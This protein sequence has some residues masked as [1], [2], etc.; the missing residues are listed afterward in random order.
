[1]E[2]ELHVTGETANTLR[3]PGSVAL[4]AGGARPGVPPVAAETKHTRPGRWLTRTR[5]RGV[6]CSQ[7]S[8]DWATLAAMGW[9]SRLVGHILLTL[10]IL[11]K[12]GIATRDSWERPANLIPSY[13]LR[14]VG[15]PPWYLVDYCH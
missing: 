2:V 9:P 12:L 3:R 1:M 15:S 4:A 10:F 7:A 14:G 8:R 13:K 5:S 11:T 6:I